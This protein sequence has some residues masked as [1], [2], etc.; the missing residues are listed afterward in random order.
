[1]ILDQKQPQ[2]LS[3]GF[4]VNPEAGTAS[5]GGRTMRARNAGV[6]SVGACR[7]PRDEGRADARGG[8]PGREGTVTASAW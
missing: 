2:P 4:A 6:L 5:P 7:G 8:G 1:V 3:R